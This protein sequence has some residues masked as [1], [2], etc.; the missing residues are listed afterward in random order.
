MKRALLILFLIF[1][2]SAISAEDLTGCWVI[3]QNQG[4]VKISKINSRYKFEKESFYRGEINNTTGVIICDGARGT[5]TY[6]NGLKTRMKITGEDC[7]CEN[8]IE[9]WV[10][11]SDSPETERFNVS[12]TWA[13]AENK[14]V[15]SQSGD[16][17]SGKK[18]LR[19]K[20]ISEYKGIIKE[21]MISLREHYVAGGRPD[22]YQR[23]AVMDK[24]KILM[25]FGWTGD[26]YL[27][28]Q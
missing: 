15:F 2:L 11:V 5:I 22:T 16:R 26:T 3:R 10:R 17:I 19:D 18:Y 7:L 9:D 6:K 24:D 28:R 20:L 21:H 14:V 4:Q 8:N 12:G 23:M 1:A 13:E 25:N 27:T